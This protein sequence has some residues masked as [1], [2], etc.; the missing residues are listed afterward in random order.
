MCSW[1]N[2]IADLI[3]REGGDNA[4]P[5][6]QKKLRKLYLETYLSRPK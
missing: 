1:R 5:E 2:A 4:D 3:E 6:E